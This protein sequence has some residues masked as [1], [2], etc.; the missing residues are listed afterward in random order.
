MIR[1][2]I[3][4]VRPAGSHASI[5]VLL[6]QHRD[7]AVSC[8]AHD[9]GGARALLAEGGYDAALIDLELPGGDPLDLAAAIRPGAAR[10]FLVRP[11][12]PITELLDACS[13]EY[14][15]KPVE[16]RALDLVLRKLRQ[17]LVSGSPVAGLGPL[18][19][20]RSGAVRRLVR[21]EHVWL[22]ASRE[23]YTEV[24]LAGAVRI[25]VRRTLQQWLELLPPRQFARVHRSLVI[26]LDGVGRI[27]RASAGGAKLH[28]ADSALAPLE[29]KRRHWPTL[30]SRLE[31]WRVHGR[32]S[33]AP[34]VGQKSIAVRPFA[35]MSGDPANEPFCD[36]ISEEL[37]DVLAKIPALR[38]A[39]RTSAFYFKHKAVP[40]GE[41]ARQLGV[42]YV[43]EGSVRRTADRV[44]IVAQ[45]I[46]GA[47]G[48][49]LWSERFERDLPDSLTVQDEIAA[50]VAANLQLKLGAAERQPVA[51]D[52]RAHWLMMEGRHFW[53][54]RT[55]D[56]F[57]RAEAAFTHALAIDPRLAPA[58]AGLADVYNVR[59]LY[60]LADGEEGV[61]DDLT[62]AR[63]EAIAA[64]RLDPTL[65][66]PHATLGFVAFHEGR[67]VEAGREFGRVV[68]KNPNYATGYQFHAWTL[69]AQ[70]RLDLALVEYN[71]SIERDPLSFINIDWH[72]AM[73]M[74]AGKLPE[75]L[76]ANERAAALRPDIFVGNL[77]QR[78]PILL[79]L[80]RRDEAVATARRVRGLG[81]GLPF[82]RNSD[83]DA[84]FV[85]QQAGLGFE[86]ADYG[87][88]ILD[89]LTPENYLR[90]FILSALGRH[91]EALP[92]LERT[93]TIMQPQ[94]YYSPV[95]D[96]V[97][98]RAGFQALIAGLGRNHEYRV[99][100]ETRARMSGV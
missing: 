9:V 19:S 22:V 77:P 66:E 61:A 81:R 46:R 56:G 57:T 91:D 17:W 75:A 1:I 95:W 80:G 44:R 32:P 30:R 89:V 28:F 92:C 73:L 2:L 84:I 21:P 35:N 100:R 8:E 99:A 79:A 88:E 42:E 39:A 78:A 52:P 18:I 31:A 82:R 62:R 94:L 26:N 4:Q 51:I 76:A 3:A 90:G 54:L 27:V 20:I 53:N 38:V 5:R 87:K 69:C 60:R 12:P 93:P 43:G 6:E 83:A 64:L 98:E 23:N 97:R 68:R 47:D 33:A 70:G 59:A 58:R 86:A 48:F 72:A 37:L 29:V 15:V 74:L 45:L 50:E 85:L 40:I 55:P 96:P 67:L 10:V 41:M 63:Q 65:A 11:D 13:A 25:F 49:H 14:L 34:P 7:F 24:T 71:K 36:G 16:P